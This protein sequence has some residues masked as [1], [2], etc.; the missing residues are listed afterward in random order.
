MFQPTLLRITKLLLLSTLIT[1]SVQLLATPTANTETPKREFLRLLDDKEHKALQ[2]SIVR[3]SSADRELNV[4][5]VSAVH[6]AD[7]QYYQD[8]NELFKNY[9]IVLYELVAPE[10]TRITKGKKQSYNLLSMI[11][12]GMKNSLGLFFQLEE[13]D[14]GPAN[15]VHADMTPIEF[16]ESMKER[17]ESVLGTLINLWRAGMV[18]QLSGNSRQSDLE[19]ISAL[20][21][22]DREHALKTLVAKEFENMGGVLNALEGKDGSTLITERNKKALTV[23]RK[24]IGKGN[25]SIAI[26][27]GAAHMQDFEQR[28]ETEFNLHAVSEQWIDAWDLNQ[29]QTLK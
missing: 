8:L 4:D 28:L 5:L 25:K 1:C 18:Q 2:V 10:G 12:L 19:F 22:T 3:Y 29:V 26:F 27:Y 20:F 15:F 7:R 23:L 14:Y 17:G 24:E 13:V 16:S 6:V 21:A 11:Q 9:E